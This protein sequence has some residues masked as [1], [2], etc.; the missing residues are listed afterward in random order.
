MVVTDPLLRPDEDRLA[1]ATGGHVSLADLLEQR[2]KLVADGGMA[3]NEM[4]IVD[5]GI[6]D[7]DARYRGLA[8]RRVKIKKAI[9]Y[10]SALLSCIC[11]GSIM[12]FSL[13]APQF[14]THMGYSQV[15]VNLLSILGEAGMY[16][17]TPI[18]GI[19]ADVYGSAVLS[20]LAAMLFGVA[21]ALAAWAYAA[22]LPYFTMMISF[23]L[24]GGGTSCMYFGSITACAKTFTSNRGLALGL[25]ITAYGL[26]SLWQSQ[27]AAVFYIDRQS[28]EVR[29]PGLFSF[30][31][32]FLATIGLIAT[33]GYHF[34]YKPDAVVLSAKELQ[35]PSI[36]LLP[37]EEAPL[38]ED[39][40]RAH[41]GSSITAEEE[42]RDDDG[43]SKTI[44]LTRSQMVLAFA[45]DWTAWGVAL[46][47][48]TAIGPGEM[49]LNNMGSLIRSLS[50]P[51]PSAATNISILSFS[52]ASMRI[53]AGVV[54]DRISSKKGRRYSRMLVM[55]FFTVLL[56]FGHFFVGLGGLQ[57][58]NGWWFWTVSILLGA[59]YGAIFTLAPTIVSLVWG[60]E[61]FGMIYGV[62]FVFPAM[63]SIVYELIYA[64]I[65]DYHTHGERLCY[66][67]NC[68]QDTF[69]I[70]GTSCVIAVITWICVWRLGW[71][72]RGLFI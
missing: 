7:D 55:L 37:D 67:L 61:R 24:I 66:G 72:R 11:A 40:L 58:S 48:F 51:G 25:P 32:I 4:S 33:V 63:G 54:S 57:V 65:Y 50:A 30:F 39:S 59:G 52:S 42:D 60:A 23:L 64:V 5:D 35:P 2:A 45:K 71:R 9:T 29:V 46:G 38:L 20:F 15:Q 17:T 70:T 62:L 6:L 31:A 41:N 44:A 3:A 8:A 19:S 34:G 28:G 10:A 49:F 43:D 1:A 53:I 12:I 22:Q 36:R 27:V 21:Y 18:V 13:Y 68:Y 56:V 14:Q 69:L 47:L 26:S 16:L